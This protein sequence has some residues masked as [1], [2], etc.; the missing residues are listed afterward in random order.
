MWT[1]ATYSCCSLDIHIL[2]VISLSA[3]FYIPRNV[4]FWLCFAWE[5][6]DVE[7]NLHIAFSSPKYL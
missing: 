2:L 4:H 7:L 1:K 5:N 6:L 3:D